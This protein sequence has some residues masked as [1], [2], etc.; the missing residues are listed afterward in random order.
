MT[1]EERDSIFIHRLWTLRDRVQ[2]GL[3][4]TDMIALGYACGCIIRARDL[5]KK[6]KAI[7]ELSK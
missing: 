4:N 7:Q 2:D 3:A 5:E 1:D 6:L